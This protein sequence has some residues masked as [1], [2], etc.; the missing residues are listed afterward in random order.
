M[1][2]SIVLKQK[3]RVTKLQAR[4]GQL[5]NLII[6]CSKKRLLILWVQLFLKSNFSKVLIC[7][8]Q[9]NKILDSFQKNM[10]IIRIIIPVSLYQMILDFIN[11]LQFQYRQTYWNHVSSLES[12]LKPIWLV[13]CLYLLVTVLE[14][15][16]ILEFFFIHLIRTGV[17][18]FLWA[19][20]PAY[21][22]RF[23]EHIPE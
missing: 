14:K 6:F 2:K 11:N 12:P 15:R 21:I 18:T 4:L 3:T 23:N 20:N 10:L 17:Q 5:L 9:N 13:F 8:K 7:Y 22:L 19:S 16:K 1:L